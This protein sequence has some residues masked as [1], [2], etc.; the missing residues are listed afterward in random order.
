MT[1]RPFSLRTLFASF[2]GIA[3][4]VA[5]PVALAVGE[6][7]FT[8]VVDKEVEEIDAQGRRKVKTI[9][10]EKVLPGEEVIYTIFFSNVSEKQLGGVVITDPVPASTRYVAGTAFGPGT[11]ISYSVDGGGVYS[12]PDRLTVMDET[13]RQRL[14]KPAEYTNIRWLYKPVLKPNEKGYVSFRAI[15]R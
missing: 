3:M 15:V 2:A 12:S 9:P 6:V 5:S 10:A 8:I 13:G 1:N 14:A 4:F 7:Q 11:D